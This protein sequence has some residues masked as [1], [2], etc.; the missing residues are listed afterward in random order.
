MNL[1]AGRLALGEAS[2]GEE[3]VLVGTEKP[4]GDILDFNLF[5]DVGDEHV[6]EIGEER[7]IANPGKPAVICI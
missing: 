7:H 4:F 6:E 3:T 5:S 2:S 1:S